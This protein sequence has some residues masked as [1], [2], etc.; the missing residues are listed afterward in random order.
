MD[1][2][3]LARRAFLKM[4]GLM[5]TFGLAAN[6]GAAAFAADLVRMPFANGVRVLERFPQ[7]RALILLRTRPPL[8]RLRWRSSTTGSLLPTTPF[9]SAGTW[10]TFPPRLTLIASG[11]AYSVTSR[12]RWQSACATC[13]T[14]FRRLSWRPSTN[15]QAIAAASFFPGS[16]VANGATARW[17]T[18]YGPGCGCAI[19]SPKHARAP[20]AQF[21]RFNGLDKGTQPNTPDFLKSLSVDHA[22]DGEVMI[23]Y[24]MNHQALPM[25][26][27]FPLRLV[28]PGWFATYWVKA[29]TDIEVL[30]HPDENFWMKTAYLVPDTPDA[31]IAPGQTGVKMVPINRMPPRSFI[32]SLKDSDSLRA[33]RPAR[34]GGIAFGGDTGVAKVLFSHDGG[35]QWQDSRLE[36]DYGKY[37]FRRFQ[38]EFTPPQTGTLRLMVRAVNNDGLAQPLRPNWN[39]G[40]Y[41]RN[42]V[43]QVQVRVA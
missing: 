3:P 12:R 38:A 21:V 15:V 24:G 42:V 7:K 11:C 6:T 4:L 14:I 36:K 19:C 22:M 30:D 5:G 31:N 9:M 2:S 13:C 18:P 17:A 1:K 23:A 29:L 39:A 26:N 40:G 10:P 16:R 25:L 35:N 32:T 33:G 41:A 27:G 34:I 8:S 20:G 43:E 37:S 28:V